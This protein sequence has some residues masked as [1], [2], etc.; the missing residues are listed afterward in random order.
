MNT[1]L[2]VNATIG[3]SENLFLVQISSLFSEL[4]QSLFDPAMNLTLTLKALD[5]ILL[6][7]KVTIFSRTEFICNGGLFS[8]ETLFLLKGA[9]GAMK[10][11]SLNVGL[12]K[13]LYQER[14]WVL[15]AKKPSDTTRSLT[16][17]LNRVGFFLS[18]GTD[19]CAP[20]GLPRIKDVPHT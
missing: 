5:L 4:T 20:L 12:F 1:V 19:P 16:R 18:Q 17:D 6:D 10:S 14:K 2:F 15:S 13:E 7:F 8:A 3:F 11:N 9:H